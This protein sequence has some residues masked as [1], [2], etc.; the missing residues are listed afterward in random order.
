M[1]L[2]GEL[3]GLS[4][5]VIGEGDDIASRVDGIVAGVAPGGGV[6][7]EVGLWCGVQ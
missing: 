7:E 5:E 3:L 6:R 4:L 1:R 2:C